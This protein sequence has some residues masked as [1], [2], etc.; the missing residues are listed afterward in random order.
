MKQRNRALP[1]SPFLLAS[2]LLFSASLYVMGEGKDRSERKE[3]RKKSDLVAKG[4]VEK[5]CRR[6]RREKKAEVIDG[7]KDETIGGP[8]KNTNREKRKQKDIICFVLFFPASPTSY[9]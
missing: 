7:R 4:T 3:K 8:Q 1:S 9:L 6:G 5:S 2:L